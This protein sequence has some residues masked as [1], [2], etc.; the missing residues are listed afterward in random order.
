MSSG[1]KSTGPGEGFIS[2]L[3]KHGVI[4]DA[5]AA[6]MSSTFSE[7]REFLQRMGKSLAYLRTNAASLAVR[8][9]PRIELAKL[10]FPTEVVEIFTR[11]EALENWCLAFSEDDDGVHIA[12]DNNASLLFA[13]VRSL[14]LGKVFKYHHAE[15]GDLR[16]AIHRAY[17]KPKKQKAKKASVD[18]ETMVWLVMTILDRALQEDGVKTIEIETNKDDISIHVLDVDGQSLMEM[19]AAPAGAGINIMKALKVLAEVDP[20]VISEI[21]DGEVVFQL[22]VSDYKFGLVVGPTKHGE[23]A[24]LTV[25]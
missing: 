15:A 14:E 19:P 2:F 1:K 12:V 4:G 3:K 25:K 21:Q 5:E 24:I 20:K 10:S 9:F 11:D 16:K 13:F 17:P 8:N 7:G 22:G 23:K 18:G 6:D